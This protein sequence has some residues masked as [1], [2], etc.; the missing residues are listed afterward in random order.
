MTTDATTRY[1]CGLLSLISERQAAP[2][3]KLSQEI[4]AERADDLDVLWRL[5]SEEEQRAFD[6]LVP[7][8]MREVCKW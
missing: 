3:G 8:A 6:G 5:M 1:V 2:G 4:E 7:V